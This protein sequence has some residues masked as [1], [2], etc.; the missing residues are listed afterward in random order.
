M[1]HC[2]PRVFWFSSTLL[3]KPLSLLLALTQVPLLSHAPHHPTTHIVTRAL[4]ALSPWLAG[5]T[6]PSDPH[7]P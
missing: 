4:A 5:R 6:A 2:L 1:R 7:Q 3:Y